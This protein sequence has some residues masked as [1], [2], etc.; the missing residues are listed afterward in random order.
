[1]I[2]YLKGRLIRKSASSAVIETAGV[3]YSVGLSSQTVEQLPE[4]GSITELEIYH[5]RTEA[6]EKLYGFSGLRDKEIFEK[7]IT[8][9]G[10]GPKV[11]LGAM[12]GLTAD[13]IIQAI[14]NGD[15]RTLALAP[16]IGRKTAER[17]TLELGDKLKDMDVQAAGES[18]ESSR[19][20]PA[21]REAVSALE[22]LGYRK[23]EA[24]RAVQQIARE[25][26]SG[27]ADVQSLIRSALQLLQ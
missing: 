26:G 21:V 22:A 19:P 17:I 25:S 5:H 27:K 18:G 3:G 1:M 8:V 23:S 16:G 14:V 2:A 15:A 12:S 20:A 11:G 7:L 4:V 24:E 10:I 13:Q 6:D 9:K